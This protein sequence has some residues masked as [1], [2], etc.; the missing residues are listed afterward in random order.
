MVPSVAAVDGN[1]FGALLRTLAQAVPPPTSP[2]FALVDGVSVSG[3]MVA[4]IL[5]GQCVELVELLP[6]NLELLKRMERRYRQKWV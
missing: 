5:A 4:K 6:D 2:D 3:K 1:S